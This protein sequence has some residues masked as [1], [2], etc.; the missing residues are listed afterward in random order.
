MIIVVLQHPK[1]THVVGHAR[2]EG[3]GTH[4]GRRFSMAR[5]LRTLV[6][7]VL[8]LVSAGCAAQVDVPATATRLVPEG[9][10][11][12]PNFQLDIPKGWTLEPTG[13]NQWRM[14]APQASSYEG[15]VV[16]TDGNIDSF[17]ARKME[18]DSASQL[19]WLEKLSAPKTRNLT[20]RMLQ[21]G[22][23]KS[24]DSVLIGCRQFEFNE[25]RFESCIWGDPYPRAE[26]RADGYIGMRWVSSDR[27]AD[28]QLRELAASVMRSFIVTP[29]P[30]REYERRR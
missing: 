29:M 4:V 30:E 26:Q 27:V 11:V 21:S 24:R 28:A 13:P 22:P 3:A 1:A 18:T 15:W 9:R 14:V 16:C 20:D 17:Q 2:A 7:A 5:F 6:V 23:E 25:D 8:G 19:G 10:V 12:C